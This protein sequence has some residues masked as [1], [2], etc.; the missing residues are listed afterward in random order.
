MYQSSQSCNWKEKNADAREM[1]LGSKR[2]DLELG[3]GER[4]RKEEERRK[5]RKRRRRR[6]RKRSN[7]FTRKLLIKMER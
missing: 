4:R 7:F 6:K 1:N 2:N 3:K 5:R